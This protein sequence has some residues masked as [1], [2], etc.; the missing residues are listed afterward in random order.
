MLRIAF[1]ST[2]RAEFGIMSSFIKKIEEDNNFESLLFVGGTHIKSEYGN[3]IEEITKM[4]IT[5]TD[6][7]DYIQEGDSSYNIATSSGYCAVKVA[8]LFEKY[9]FDLISIL[10]DRYELIPIALTAILFNK[11]IIHWGGG[12]FTEGVIDNQIR[13]MLTKAAHIHFVAAEKYAENIVNMGEDKKRVCVTGSPVIETFKKSKPISKIDLF[14]D[15][16]L[17][18]NAPVILLT[19]HPVTIEFEI[20]PLLQIKN[21]FKALM[22]FN[23]QI[24]ITAPNM[25]NDRQIILDYIGKQVISNSNIFYF[26]SLGIKRYHSLIPH[27]AFLIGNSSSG[28]FEA[29][30]FK[31]PTVNIGDRQKGRYK[32]NSIIDSDYSVESIIDSINIANDDSFKESL[33]Q[34]K[35][36]FGDGDASEKAIR[37][38]KTLTIDEQLIRKQ[39]VL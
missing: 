17:K 18:I 26:E 28:I 16:G 27:C 15:L 35:Y 3:T 19:Y 9:D 10:G 4:G 7:F 13:H 24:V 14:D 11:P 1:F 12:E 33:K 2:T 39:G 22:E 6:T 25:E 21:L 20:T 36:E 32:H 38:L 29:P 34:M 37:F 8:D 31:I 30:Y 23:C 5:I